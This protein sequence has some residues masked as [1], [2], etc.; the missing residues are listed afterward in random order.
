MFATSAVSSPS[1]ACPA[2]SSR[3]LWQLRHSAASSAMTML[4]LTHV[5]THL[6]TQ[7][8]TAK[9]GAIRT[10][11][12]SVGAPEARP[13]LQSQLRTAAPLDDRRRV[14]VIQEELSAQL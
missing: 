1:V 14:P 6:D 2:I 4:H 11:E 10:F 12:W 9:M 8:A 7:V 3:L 13:E 5:R